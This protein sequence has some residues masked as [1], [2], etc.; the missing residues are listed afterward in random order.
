MIIASFFGDEV[1]V[2]ADTTGTFYGQAMVAGKTYLVARGGGEFP[3]ID[4]PEAVAVDAGGD[5]LFTDDG[6]GRIRAISP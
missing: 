6:T 4:G 3:G 2:L 1:Q 5:I